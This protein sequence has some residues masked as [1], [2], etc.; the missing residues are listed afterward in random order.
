MASSYTPILRLTLPVT[1]ELQGTWG[2]TVNNGITSLTEAAIAGTAAVVMSDANHTL[3]VANGA[4]D[5]ARRMFVT[6][7]GTLSA[8]RN[9][10]CPA[11]SKMY[12]VRNNTTGGQSIVFKTSAGTGITV[13][14]GQSALLY[15]DGTNVVEAFSAFAG[16]AGSATVLQTT[17]TI[18]GQNFNGSA[19]VTGNLT[20]VGNI[21]GTGAVALTATSGTLAL[22]ATGANIITASTN[23]SERL[24]I[25]A[26]GNLGLGVTPSAWVS[27]WKA[28][29][30]TSGGSSLYGTLAIGGVAT[31]AFFDAGL[32]WRYK[33]SFAAARYEQDSTGAHA[34]FTAPSGTAGN[35]ISFTQAMTL[36]ASGNLGIGTSSPSSRL[37]V[38]GTTSAPSFI[39]SDAAATSSQVNIGIGVVTSGRPFIGTNAASNPL[40]IGTRSSIELLFLTNST[41]RARIDSSGNLLV[42]TSDAD[43]TTGVGMKLRASATG[44]TVAVVGSDTTSS[45]AAF[46]AYS[47]GAGAYRFQ[48]GYNG[49]IF[50]TNT[51][52]SALSDA[53]LKENVRD[54]ETGLQHVMELRPRRFDW[55]NGDGRGVAGFV[56]QEVE[57]VLPDLVQDYQYSEGGTKKTLKMGD[58]LPTVVKAVQDLK[59]IVDAQAERIAALEKQ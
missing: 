52:I 10:I 12:V 1:G 39:V 36:A 6:L 11:V 31:N 43:F 28:L 53:S 50:A 16:N 15:C 33:A 13:A 26:S 54:L 3:T 35:P 51:S 40:E 44:P 2:D 5:E 18:W 7:T 41:E 56:A 48:V 30:V 27:G 57:R 37:H 42:G 20:S 38:N 17:R 29:D 47:T 21:T 59:A 34:W 9:V 25:D 22:A 8:T 55:K 46:T 24:R 49:T 58:I 4:A 45:T 19:N 23:G 32:V 14:N